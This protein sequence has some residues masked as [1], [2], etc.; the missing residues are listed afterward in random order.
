MTTSQEQY[1]T[2][3]AQLQALDC[4][5]Q[6]DDSIPPDGSVKIKETRTPHTMPPLRLTL[7]QPL[8][9]PVMFLACRNPSPET[10]NRSDGRKV[11]NHEYLD[12]SALDKAW[13][14]ALSRAP[15]A[16]HITFDLRLPRP[17]AG[18]SE[19]PVQ[20]IY[21]DT[22]IPP[23]GQDF[24]ISTGSVMRLVATIAIVARM[25]VQGDLHLKISHDEANRMSMRAISLLRTWLEGIAKAKDT[26]A[27]RTV[28][29]GKV[30]VETGGC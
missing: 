22:E 28:D 15:P 21:W 6:P 9:D 30:D 5:R 27:T 7:L 10:T 8:A 12:I 19:A 25:R 4:A 18:D 17:P 23:S 16:S 26:V 3:P 11:I 20:T 1:I 14:D 29:I 24:G 13:R 2:D